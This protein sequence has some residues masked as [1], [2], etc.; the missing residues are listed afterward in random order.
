MN[1]TT[2]SKIVSILLKERNATPSGTIES[3]Q[4]YTIGSAQVVFEGGVEPMH[5]QHSDAMSA[6]LETQKAFEGVGGELG[7]KDEQDVVDMIK[8]IRSQR[9]DDLQ[10]E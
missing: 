7:L 3:A 8:Q 5:I 2:E 4:C 6:L 10:C 9:R 1:H